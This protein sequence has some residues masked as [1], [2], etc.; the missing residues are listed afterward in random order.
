MAYNISNN[1]LIAKNTMYLYIRMIVIMV[2]SLFTSRIILD[3]LG[4]QD[5]G[6]NN[7]ING[8]VIL[9]SFLNTALL[10]GTQRFLNY[11]LGKNDIAKINSVFCMSMNTYL[12]LSG[13]IILLG[14]TI[15]L[16]FIETKLNIPTERHDAAIWVYQFT[17]LQFII[18]LIK[19]PYNATIIAY[20]KMNFYA[21]ISFFEVVMKLVF[22]YSIYVT[23]YDKLIIFSFLNTIIVFVI[24]LVYK[25]YCNKNYVISKF[26]FFWDKTVFR[27]IFCFSGWSLFGSVANLTSQQGLNI[28]LNIFYGVTLNAAA[29]V[30]NQVSSAVNSFISNFQIAI[31]PQIT[32][33]YASNDISRFNNLIIN[34]SKFSFY[35]MFI[36]VIPISVAIDTILDIW[37]VSV[38][39]YT[40][41]FCRL[42][43]IFLC[44]DAFTMPIVFGVQAIGNIR[45]YQILMTLLIFLNFPFAWYVLSAGYPPYSIWIVRIGVNVLVILA[46]CIYIWKTNG[47]PIGCYVQKTFLPVGLVTILTLPLPVLLKSFFARDTITDLIVC[48][49][50]FVYSVSIV[51]LVGIT[52]DERKMLFS[53]ISNK[54]HN[55][56]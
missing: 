19:I 28:L 45:N 40:S 14:E 20:E 18:N 48:I 4:T 55:R 3:A 11:Y 8:V 43:L 10:T 47:F 16:W 56:K 27:E 12:I 44:M 21:Y 34:T 46:R 52:K 38:P 33:S 36:I 25:F 15:G 31:Q 6:I 39:E 41:I 2:V 7:I 29:G 13:I 35:L 5:Y 54:F 51:F 22:A 49:L 9:F 42:T 37:L 1:K 30:A 32:K 50:S 23:T 17:L 26:I 24:L 53:I